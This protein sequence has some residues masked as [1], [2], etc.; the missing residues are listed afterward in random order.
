MPPTSGTDPE[1]VLYLNGLLQTQR[2]K[3]KKKAFWFL[4]KKNNKSKTTPLLS[5]CFSPYISLQ[6]WQY[7]NIA[8]L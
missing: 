2:L 1:Y 7:L 3:K 4:S 5:F 6:Y 8:V